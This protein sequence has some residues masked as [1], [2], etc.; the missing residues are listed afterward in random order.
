MR[1]AIPRH[2]PVAGLHAEDRRERELQRQRT[3]G[4]GIVGAALL[5]H[6]HQ[7]QGPGGV[8]EGSRGYVEPAAV[9]IRTGRHEEDE[10]ECLMGIDR[11]DA[12]ERQTRVDRM[13]AEFRDAQSRRFG[14]PHNTALESKPDEGLK[15]QRLGKPLSP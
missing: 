3:H 13:I 11:D 10:V 8:V 1:V 7:Q 5:E 6:F 15:A 2:G 9:Q 12:A 14:K 4:G